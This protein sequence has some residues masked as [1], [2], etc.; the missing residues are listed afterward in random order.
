MAAFFVGADVR[1]RTLADGT[2]TASSRRRLR[3]NGR[4]KAASISRY[5][6]TLTWERTD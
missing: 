2:E 5:I 6:N 4:P 3:E 1:R